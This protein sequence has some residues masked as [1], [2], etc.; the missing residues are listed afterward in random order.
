[1][2]ESFLTLPAQMGPIRSVHF[3]PDGK[4]L[5]TAEP[6]D[7][8]HIYDASTGLYEEQQTIEFFGE[9][10]GVNFDPSGDSLFIGNADDKVGSIYEFGR[11]RGK[12]SAMSWEDIIL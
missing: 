2:T 12:E 3:S 11:V 9:I 7:Y 4:Y 5:A 1:M 8:V 10:A 6:A